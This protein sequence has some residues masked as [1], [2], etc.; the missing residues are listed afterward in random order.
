ME[1]GFSPQEILRV[2]VQVEEKGKKLFG[3]L[4]EQAEFEQ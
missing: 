3:I 2:A 1:K 4:E